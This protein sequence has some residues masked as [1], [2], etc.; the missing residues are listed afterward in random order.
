[1]PRVVCNDTPLG[2]L[3]QRPVAAHDVTYTLFADIDAGQMRF[4]SHHGDTTAFV[5]QYK[6]RN[7]LI[8]AAHIAFANHLSLTLSPDIIWTVI[9]QGIAQHI[10]NNAEKFR[11]VLVPHTGKEDLVVQRDDLIITNTSLQ[12]WKDI[13]NEFLNQLNEKSKCTSMRNAMQTDFSTTGQVQRTVLNMTVMDS[14]KS[15]Y[16]Y[17]LQTKCD[18]PIVNIAGTKDDWQTLKCAL[19]VFDDLDLPGYKQRLEYILDQF[20]GA[21]ENKIDRQ[22]WNGI[23]LEKGGRGSGAQTQVSGWI[24]QLFLYVSD[25]LFG[26]DNIYRSPAPN[27]FPS[28]MSATPFTWKYYSECLAMKFYSGIVGIAV[29]NDGVEPVLGFAVYETKNEPS[30]P[31]RHGVDENG[32]HFIADRKRQ[33]APRVE[34]EKRALSSVELWYQNLQSR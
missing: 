4:S 24:T 5:H 23:Y 21:Y 18:I 28:G 14:M 27:E 26:S 32:E 8:A 3:N 17:T 22:F 7:N 10:S 16:T 12:D 9:M 2:K 6:I 15:Y 25:A 13:S 30:I 33:Q 20:I 29:T 1:M 34:S 11:S 19:A 31:D